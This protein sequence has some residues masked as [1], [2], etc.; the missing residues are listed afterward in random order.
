MVKDYKLDPAGA[1]GLVILDGSPSTIATGQTGKRCFAWTATFN[2]QV[3]FV[4]VYAT[5][6]TAALTFD[7]QQG[8]VTILTAPITPTSD[9]VVPGV[10]V[11]G[12]SI[13]ALRFEKN[14]VISVY[15]TTNGSGAAVNPSVMIGVRPY[16]MSGE[17][18]LL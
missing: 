10:L 11:G 14:E 4:Q 16:P 3:V 13:D 5:A 17:A 9:A 6:V 12:T 1:G 15:Y 18:A 7:V 2:G 8:G